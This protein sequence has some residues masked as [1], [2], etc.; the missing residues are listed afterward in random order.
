MD[1]NFKLVFLLIVILVSAD[2]IITY[3]NIQAVDKNFPDVDKFEI[4]RNPLAKYLF[5]N[6][7]LFYGNVLYWI[8]SIATFLIAL[9]GID[10]TL[11][12]FNVPNSMSISL[13]IMIVLYCLALG[14]NLFFLMKYSKIIP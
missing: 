7:G 14:N 1:I 2:K 3:Y 6:F 8:L 12:L 13:Y 5:K 4:E 10:W 9:I 11:R